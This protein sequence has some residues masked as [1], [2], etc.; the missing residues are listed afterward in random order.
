MLKRHLTLIIKVDNPLRVNPPA[1]KRSGEKIIALFQ[2]F[3]V[4]PDAAP[5]FG[6]DARFEYFF[7]S[8]K[9]AAPKIRGTATIANNSLTGEPAAFAVPGARQRAVL[10]SFGRNTASSPIA[11]RNA[12]T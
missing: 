5:D 3:A 1:Y 8:S 2:C 6:F 4:R 7:A 10:G 12:Q 11:G 9:M